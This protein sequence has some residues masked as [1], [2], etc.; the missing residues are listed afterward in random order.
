MTDLLE[1]MSGS[2]IAQT[3]EVQSLALKVADMSDPWYDGAK[4]PDY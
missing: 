2:Q 4:E 3:T 1:K